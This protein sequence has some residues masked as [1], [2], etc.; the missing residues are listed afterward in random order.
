MYILAI[1]HE[2]IIFLTFFLACIFAVDS[3][4]RSSVLCDLLLLKNHRLLHR[5]ISGLTGVREGIKLLKIWLHQ[6]ELD[7]V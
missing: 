3:N 1:E 6:R 4:Y 7:F 5:V 2:A